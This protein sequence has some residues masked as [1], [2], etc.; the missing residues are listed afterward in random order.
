MATTDDEELDF[1]RNAREHEIVQAKQDEARRRRHEDNV[2]QQAKKPN[3]KWFPVDRELVDWTKPVDEE[4]PNTRKWNRPFQ[5]PYVVVKR[6]VTAQKVTIRK[7]NLTTKQKMEKG[8]TVNVKQLRP[9]LEF[10]YLARPHQLGDPTELWPTVMPILKRK[11]DDNTEKPK[12]TVQWK[13][14][15]IPKEHLAKLKAVKDHL[16]YLKDDFYGERNEEY[17]EA[18]P[19]CEVIMKPEEDESPTQN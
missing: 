3:R 7:W 17:G 13:E 9:T 4:N 12:K 11:D 5:G 14:V 16:E 19:I 2:R 6:N 15:R 10:E 18:F 1:I 8:I